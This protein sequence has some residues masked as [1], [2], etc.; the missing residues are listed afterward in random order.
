[1]GMD[2]MKQH[3]AVIQC[4]KKV[5]VLTTPKGDKISVEVA[6]QPPPT[7]TM[8]QLSDDDNQPE[9]VVDEF[10]DVFPDDLLG[11]PPDRDIEFIIDLLPRT[12]PI[13]KCPHRMGADELEELKKQLKEL[14]NKGFICPSSSP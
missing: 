8:N 4:Q 13:A 9:R 10:P 7:A 6:I 14:Q 2:W 1:M 3:R 5:V 12:T 11:M